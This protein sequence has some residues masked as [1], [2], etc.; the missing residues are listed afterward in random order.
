MRLWCATGYNP[1][2]AP[3][4]IIPRDEIDR[5]LA[6]GSVVSLRESALRGVSRGPEKVDESV[7][8]RLPVHLPH[9]V[10]TTSLEGFEFGHLPPLQLATMPIFVGIFAYIGPGIL[11]TA[12]A[13]G[14]GELIWWP[15]LTAKYGSVFLGV[16]IPAS[17]LQ[18]WLNLELCRF[19]VL[20]GETPMTGFTRIGRWFA[21]LFWGG[22]F[23]AYASAGGTAL[24]ALTRFPDGWSP[25]GQSLFWGYL[26]IGIY[27]FAW[28]SAGSFTPCWRNSRW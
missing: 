1:A 25:K 23:G 2:A 26:T 21:W 15:Y 7:N 3:A 4:I 6:T 11:W 16:L 18:Y 8:L 27:L 12:L 24:A 28:F 9:Q 20:T 14:S 13:Q 5:A 10:H 19:T 22:V 17:M